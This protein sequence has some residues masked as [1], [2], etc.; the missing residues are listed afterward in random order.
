LFILFVLPFVVCPIQI[1][2]HGRILSA[3]KGEGRGEGT[4]GG[5]RKEEKV[6]VRGKE[7]KKDKE[8]PH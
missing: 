3:G 5:G 6:L 8:T 4:G 7:R 1:V 2:C